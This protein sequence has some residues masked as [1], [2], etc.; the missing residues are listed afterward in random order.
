MSTEMLSKC[1]QSINQDVNRVLIKILTGGRSRVSINIRLQTLLEHSHDPAAIHM[2]THLF[3]HHTFI[4]SCICQIL[5]AYTLQFLYLSHKT[6]YLIKLLQ[7]TKCYLLNYSSF[8]DINFSTFCIWFIWSWGFL[9]WCLD[10]LW[11]LSLKKTSYVAA[12]ISLTTTIPKLT[13]TN[14]HVYNISSSTRQEWS[15]WTLKISGVKVFLWNL[16]GQASTT[17]M[18]S[19]L[20]YRKVSLDTDQIS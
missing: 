15:F 12:N 10:N 9:L 19:L 17:C 5:C 13:L 16:T 7:E 20:N 14:Y 6:V 4:S 8:I 2:I 1:W 3:I 11:F 18:T